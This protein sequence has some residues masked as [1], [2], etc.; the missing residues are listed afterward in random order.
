M[1]LL[2]KVLTIT[3]AIAISAV[4]YYCTS[5]EQDMTVA[6]I[7]NEQSR[8]PA[9]GEEPTCGSGFYYDEVLF[10]CMPVEVK[11]VDRKMALYGYAYL[12]TDTKSLYRKLGNTDNV[13][14]AL[15]NAKRLGKISSL[16]HSKIKGLTDQVVNSTSVYAMRA[17]IN[18]FQSGL[19][20]S[21]YSAKD[22]AM[23]GAYAL[24]LEGIIDGVV[25]DPANS[26]LSPTGWAKAIE[27]SIIFAA[28]GLSFAM[29]IGT[30]VATAGLA[31]MVMSGVAYSLATAALAYCFA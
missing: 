5:P 12:T 7:D 25:S 19:N 22:R 29:M 21:S 13:Y 4:S 20:S 10:K 18:S 1:K 3:I 27:C 15:S 14:T 2:R 16:Q 23:L 30:S 8:A 28:W 11:T 26:N 9:F 17:N 6:T 24:V 31:M